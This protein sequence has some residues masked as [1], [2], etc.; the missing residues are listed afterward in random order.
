MVK[1]LP[2]FF[3]DRFI[4]TPGPTEIP[5]R[6]RMAMIREET[7]PDLDPG[8]L[9]FSRRVSDKLKTARDR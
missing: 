8:F 7:N 5:V 1:S 9:E 4:L 2:R 6:I 3:T